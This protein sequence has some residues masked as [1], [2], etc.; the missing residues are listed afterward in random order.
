MLGTCEDLAF[1]ADFLVA[2]AGQDP[3]PRP[4]LEMPE[5]FDLVHRGDYKKA[6][7]VISE[8]GRKEQMVFELVGP[9]SHKYYGERTLLMLICW[10]HACKQDPETHL[11]C[12]VAIAERSRTVI[13]RRDGRGMTA[14]MLAASSGKT[15]IVKLL[16]RLGASFL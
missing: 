1:Y 5:I 11:D 8:F 16:I 7:A 10:Q 14:L 13:N 9:T 12:A 2:S 6:L 15:H 4:P 3:E